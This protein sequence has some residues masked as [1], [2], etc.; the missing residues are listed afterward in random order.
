MKYIIYRIKK[1]PYGDQ[2]MYFTNETEIIWCSVASH[3]AKFDT[4]MEATMAFGLAGFRMGTAT[5]CEREVPVE[6]QV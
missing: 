5:R 2:K 3:A 6:A 1:T 4:E